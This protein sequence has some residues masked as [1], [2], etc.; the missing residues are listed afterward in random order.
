[1]SKRNVADE[2]VDAMG[3][4]LAMATGE[5]EPA[6]VHEVAVVPD[7]DVRAIRELMPASQ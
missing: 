3:E 6:A 4:A 2:L 5:I 7:V 1:M